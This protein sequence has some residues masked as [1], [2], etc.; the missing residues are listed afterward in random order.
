MFVINDCA[1]LFRCGFRPIFQLFDPHPGSFGT[2]I[3]P[4]TS[5]YSF[6]LIVDNLFPSGCV[7]ILSYPPPESVQFR[8]GIPVE[9]YFSSWVL[10]HL[11]AVRQILEQDQSAPG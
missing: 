3:S 10:S 11:S 4:Q 2:W 1:D 7:R 6:G 5:V 8:R 9:T